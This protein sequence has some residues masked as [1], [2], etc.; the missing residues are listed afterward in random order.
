MDIVSDLVWH[1]GQLLV[2]LHCYTGTWSPPHRTPLMVISKLAMLQL[3]VL[4]Y[5]E[6]R[7]PNLRCVMV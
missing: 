3:S 4:V 5:C 1:V 6:A 7:R 2:V